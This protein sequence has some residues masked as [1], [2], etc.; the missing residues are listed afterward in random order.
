MD[1][2]LYVLCF[3]ALTKLAEYCAYYKVVLGLSRFD[4]WLRR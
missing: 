3:L 4:T 2:A 1:K